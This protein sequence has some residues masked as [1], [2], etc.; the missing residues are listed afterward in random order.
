[1]AALMTAAQR[2]QISVLLPVFNAEKYLEK[3]LQSL[4]NQSFQNFEI[5]AMDDGS[6]DGSVEVLKKFSDPRIRIEKNEKNLGL[7]ATLN[8]GISLCQGEFIARMDADDIAVSTRLEKQC[9]YLQ[10]NPRCIL[11]STGRSAIDE[12]DQPIVSFNRPATGSPL[13]RWKLLTGNFITHP[14]VMLRKSA[15]HLP[16]FEEKYK[17][18]EDYAAWLKLSTLG[19]FEILPERL[20]KYR[21]HAEAVGQKYKMIQV[22]SAMN[23]LADHLRAQ[24]GAEFEF[25]SLALWS[26]PQDAAGFTRPA[27]FL[28]LLRWM[29]PLR[30]PF[31]KNLRGAML[32][33]AFGHYHRRLLLLLISH[34]MRFELLI[35]VLLA[36]MTSPFPKSR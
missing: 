13:I 34:R 28:H 33:R 22:K 15:L 2:P 24:Y 7:I 11:V 17:H 29:N 32:W 18:A 9:Q 21:F 36:M 27:D 5:V 1:M 25:N 19:D 31:R 4:L 6:T 26:A 35:P 20:L 8:R 23:A 16:L 3:A 12:N 30:K 14:T 10:Q